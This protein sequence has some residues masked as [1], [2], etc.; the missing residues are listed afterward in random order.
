MMHFYFLAFHSVTLLGLI[1]MLQHKVE[2]LKYLVLLLHCYGRMVCVSSYR[3][4]HVVPAS[5]MG[6]SQH[7]YCYF[8]PFPGHF[9]VL[10]LSPRCVFFSLSLK[11][12]LHSAGVSLLSGEKHRQ[13][14]D[15]LEY[16]PLIRKASYRCH[17]L[18]TLMLVPLTEGSVVE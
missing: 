3:L 4:T 5:F 1:E 16:K 12:Q 14:T 8:K 15:S 18:K 7:T 10:S 13:L 6:D 11:A 2:I 17:S 9:I